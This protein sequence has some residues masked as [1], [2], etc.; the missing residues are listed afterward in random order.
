MNDKLNYSKHI[1]CS[2]ERKCLN[3]ETFALCRSKVCAVII[4]VGKKKL[5]HIRR[6]KYPHLTFWKWHLR[7]NT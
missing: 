1:L 7:V 6:E 5:K 4:T 3:A 2:T